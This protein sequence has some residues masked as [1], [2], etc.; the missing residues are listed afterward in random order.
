MHVDPLNWRDLIRPRKLVTD[1]DTVTPTYGKFV[2]EPLERGFGLTMGNALRRILLSSLRG[3]A[4][5]QVK[6]DGVHHEFTS[7][8]E[9][10]EDVTDIVVNL[11]GVIV[12]TTLNRP[13][14]I[15]LEKR[16]PGDLKAGDLPQSETL[17]VL[18]PDH[19]IASISKGG[20]I[21][22]D[23]TVTTGRGYQP[24]DRSKRENDAIGTIPLDGVYS[25]VRKVNYL[26]TNARVGQITDYDKLTMEIWTNGTVNPQEALAYAAKILK[27]HASIF[28]TFDEAEEALVAEEAAAEPLNENLFRP[29]SELEL[30]VRATNCFRNANITLIGELV[31]RTEAEMLRTKNFGRKSLREIKEILAKMDLTLGMRIDNW[32]QLLA[33][34]RQQGH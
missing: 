25:P 11:K 14:T 27:E 4:I 8:P 18:N 6:I 20:R 21:A 34:W 10:R 19:H 31:Q 23:V 30:S 33:R 28:I 3:A 16:G 5:T 22:M 13:Q 29:V 26:V 32:N 24:A 7:I 2:C 9:V 12:K 15:R 17:K 1:S